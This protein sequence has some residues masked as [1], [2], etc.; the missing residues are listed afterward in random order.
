MS[1]VVIFGL[2]PN[3]T[4]AFFFN[5]SWVPNGSLEVFT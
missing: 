2:N 4:T 1:C 5:N 3:R